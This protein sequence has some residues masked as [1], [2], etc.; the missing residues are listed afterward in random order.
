[1]TLPLRGNHSRMPLLKTHFASTR[2]VKLKFLQAIIIFYIE[3]FVGLQ[4]IRI[5]ATDNYYQYKYEYDF[6]NN[7][8]VAQLK[9]KQS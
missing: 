9:I 4:K 3:I 2:S 5:F 8:V 7:M 1:M 6:N